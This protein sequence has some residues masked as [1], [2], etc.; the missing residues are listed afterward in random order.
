MKVIQKAIWAMQVKCTG[1][2]NGNGGCGST[3][4][5]YKQDLYRTSHHFIGDHFPSFYTTIKCCECG[6]LTDIKPEGINPRDLPPLDPP[7]EVPNL[8][9][10]I[11]KP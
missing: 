3:L 7:S 9:S 6:V 4:E 8:V 10:A 2:G 5:I 1:E 11:Q